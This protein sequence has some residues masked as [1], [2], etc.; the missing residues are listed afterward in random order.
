MIRKMIVTMLFG[1][2]CVAAMPAIVFADEVKLELY[3]AP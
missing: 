1:I 2:C 3:I